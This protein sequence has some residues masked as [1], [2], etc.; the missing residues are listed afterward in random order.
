MFLPRLAFFVEKQQSSPLGLPAGRIGVVSSRSTNEK[1]PWKDLKSLMGVVE[2]EFVRPVLSGESLLPYRISAD[3]LA[4]VPCD[5]RQLLSEPG[6]I[7]LHPGLEQWWRQAETIWERHRSSERLSLFDQLNYQSKLTKQ[8]PVP[9]LR[10]VYNRSG[11]HLVAA[12]V[13]NRR[14]LVS[15]GLYWATLATEA[16]ADFLCA[17][18]NAPATTEAV[19]PLMSYGKDERDIAKHVWQLPIPRFDAANTMHQWIVE[20]A[21]GL[22]QQIA[23][24]SVSDTL[25]FA[26]SRRHIRERLEGTAEGQ[27]LNELVYEMLT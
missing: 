20:I 1:K 12:K 15:S 21:R 16:E 25:H 7:E 5:P 4:V 19:R 9:P 3:L 18:M 26:A 17:I 13:K 24:H 22:E 10:V 27:E 8:L 14:A 23:G 11:M 6:V 2:T